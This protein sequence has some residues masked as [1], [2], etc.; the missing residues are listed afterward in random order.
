MKSKN[1]NNLPS[2]ITVELLK[3]W[4]ACKNGIDFFTRNNL[5]QLDYSTVQVEGDFKGLWSWLKEQ[6]KYKREYDERGNLTKVI[7][8]NGYELRYEYDERG[9]LTK[10]I[11]PNGYEYRYEYDERGNLTKAISPNGDED[12]Y[13]YDERGNRTKEID[14]NGDEY[15]SEYDERGNVTKKIY[16]YEG[17]LRYEYLF[18][19][20]GVLKEIKQNGKTV[21]KIKK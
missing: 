20:N 11:Y 6:G 19:D 15:K 8:P 7:S 3:S 5:D 9:N 2:K 13:E 12:R 21:C 17:E 4:G 16:P 1:N 18:D 14:P 10:K